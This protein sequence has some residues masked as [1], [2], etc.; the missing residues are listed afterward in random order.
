MDLTASSRALVVTEYVSSVIT[1][2]T[3]APS[4]H[5]LL[6]FTTRL[7]DTGEQLRRVGKCRPLVGEE[8]ITTLWL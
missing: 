4:E 6:A 8:R 2:L 1:L 7:L 5:F 3:Q